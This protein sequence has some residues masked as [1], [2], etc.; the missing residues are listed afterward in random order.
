MKVSF[1]SSSLSSVNSFMVKCKDSSVLSV[2]KVSVV[3]KKKVVLQASRESPFKI[4]VK[5]FVL[6]NIKDYSGMSSFIDNFQGLYLF[7]R[8]F[9]GI[10]FTENLLNKPFKFEP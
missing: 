2:F 1:S 4:P 7:Y 10:F 6:G 9:Q 3:R 8:K 5:E